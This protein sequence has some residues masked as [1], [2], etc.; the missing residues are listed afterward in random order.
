M[1]Q[2]LKKFEKATNIPCS[3]QFMTRVNES[4]FVQTSKVD[5]LVFGVE[6]LYA[7]HFTGGNKKRGA[8][9]LRVFMTQRSLCLEILICS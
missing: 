7:L 3:S 4:N 1:Q 6:H 2:I 9:L 8:L 5:E